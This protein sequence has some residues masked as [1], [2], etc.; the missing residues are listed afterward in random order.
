[1]V[2]GLTLELI[3]YINADAQYDQGHHDNVK[4]NFVDNA[5]AALGICNI[6][7][8]YEVSQHYSN[9]GVSEE[10]KFKKSLKQMDL[11]PD[12]LEKII[13]ACTEGALC[14]SNQFHTHLLTQF[15]KDPMA[16]LERQLVDVLVLDSSKFY[17]KHTLETALKTFSFVVESGRKSYRRNAQALHQ[18]LLRTIMYKE[19]IPKHKILQH[20][21]QNNIHQ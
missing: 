2:N 19:V 4:Y 10:S 14:G 8:V 18:W 7:D 9:N 17:K 3:H 11:V 12:G 5:L 20:L 16:I 1:M 21:T 13:P 15:E 6:S